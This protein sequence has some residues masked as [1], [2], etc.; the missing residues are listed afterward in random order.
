MAALKDPIGANLDRYQIIKGWLDKDGNLHEKVYD[1]AWSGDR[2]P[3]S[4][5][6]VPLVGSTVD[7][8]NATW[9]N[10]I[11]AP[12]LIKVWTDPEFDPTQPAFYY[13]RVIE[14]PTPR[15]TAYDAKR[16]GV[17]PLPGTTM[18]VTERGLH[19]ADLVQSVT[20]FCSPTC[21]GGRKGG[22]CVSKPTF[23]ST[24][25]KVRD[26]SNFRIRGRQGCARSRRLAPRY[27]LSRMG[28]QQ[29]V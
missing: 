26:G 7:E 22:I 16:F 2:K 18:T 21:L 29:T 6:K 20:L 12:E 13:G 3:G 9:T 23:Y 5:G 14:I 15:W 11:G 4:D 1:A 17:K 19:V 27:G 28:R 10:T 24:W 25:I 8:A